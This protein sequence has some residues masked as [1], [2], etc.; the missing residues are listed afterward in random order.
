MSSQFSNE[1][2]TNKKTN[3]LENNARKASCFVFICKSQLV[4]PYTSDVFS[5]NTSDRCEED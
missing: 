5:L 1:L 2:K 3:K 4:V